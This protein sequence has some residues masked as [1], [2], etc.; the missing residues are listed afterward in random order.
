MILIALKDSLWIT[1]NIFK[2]VPLNQS[3]TEIV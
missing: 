3:E 2:I 1:R